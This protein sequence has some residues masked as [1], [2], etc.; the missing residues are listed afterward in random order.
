[1][2]SQRFVTSLVVAAALLG[3][4]PLAAQT[5]KVGFMST[6]S[7]PGAAQGDQL[8]K[9]AKLYSKLNSGK[10]PRGVKIDLISRDDTGAN[11]D[12]A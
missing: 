6:F 2:R 7:G 4:G 12:V 9:G 8:D 1:M 5:I 10:L 11:P 3:A